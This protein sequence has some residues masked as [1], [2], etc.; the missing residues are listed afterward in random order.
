MNPRPIFDSPDYVGS[1]KLK[2][3]TS[4]VAYEGAPTVI[5]HSTSKGA[6]VSFTRTMA[7]SL[8][9]KGI[10][11]NAVAPGPS[12]TPLSVSNY[13]PDDVAIL[14]TDTPCKWRFNS[15]FIVTNSQ[16]GSSRKA[17]P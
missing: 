17:A 8:A 5:D 3:K 7:L 15:L 16:K 11:V 12:W 9:G 4:R 6:I 2:G 14:G 10:R 13:P 1:G